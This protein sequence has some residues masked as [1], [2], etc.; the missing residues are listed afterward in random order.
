MAPLPG[1]SIFSA[2][3]R[4]STAEQPSAVAACQERLEQ[5]FDGRPYDLLDAALTDTVANFPVDIQARLHAC[6]TAC[7]LRMRIAWSLNSALRGASAPR[8]QPDIALC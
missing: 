5:V 2:L 8:A 3:H 7:L 6:R 1:C 4:P